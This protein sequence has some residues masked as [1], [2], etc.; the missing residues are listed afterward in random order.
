MSNR[1]RRRKRLLKRKRYETVMKVFL[2]FVLVA[3]LLTHSATAKGQKA[4]NKQNQL[5]LSII[6][7]KRRYKATEQLRF[8]V[9]LMN[10]GK[11]DVYIFGTLDFGYS[12]SLILHIRDASGKEVQPFFD[13]LTFAS[14][15]DTS[16]F[17]K[18]LPDHFLGTK[19]YSPVNDLNM[20]RP[21][22][23]AIYVEY[24]SP[25]SASDVQLKHFW[26]KENGRL[27]SNVLNF[28]IIR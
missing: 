18:L 22:R 12:A 14:P 21:G 20:N 26:G 7:D 13:D 2:V 1:S 19:F 17:V 25:F 3:G 27:K 9:L 6:A 11:E 5:E 23:Y 4:I 24:H 16:A 15:N 8:N 28:E 10:S